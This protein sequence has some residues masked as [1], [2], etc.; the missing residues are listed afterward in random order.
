[1]YKDNTEPATPEIAPKIKYR[2]PIS[3]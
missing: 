1:M 3:L 2:V